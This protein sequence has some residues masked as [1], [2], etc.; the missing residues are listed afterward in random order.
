GCCASTPTSPSSPH[1]SPYDDP[2]AP[3][4]NTRVIT[5]HSSANA[6]ATAGLTTHAAPGP[7]S[8]RPNVYTSSDNPDII[9]AATSLLTSTP[10][11]T[12]SQLERERA[13]FFDTRW[14][15]RAEVWAAVKL[16]CESLRQ[17]D[18]EA[19]QAV[20]DAAGLTCPTGEVRRAGDKQKDGGVYDELGERYQVPLW[21]MA[22]PEGVVEDGHNAGET[23]REGGAGGQ[24]AEREEGYSDEDDDDIMLSKE[25]GKGREVDVGRIVKVRARLSDRGTDVVVRMGLEENV[26]M[27][28]RRVKESAELPPRSRVKF[29]YL[30]KMLDPSMSLATQGWRE[31]HVI[32]ALVFQ[33]P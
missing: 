7:A 25:K 20:L 32:N 27:L 1:D 23:P 28:R 11:V 18:L 12:R 21:V 31:G 19:A 33:P 22:D 3:I 8:S 24:E 2:N 4:P 13:A 16:I 26:V 6:S 5:N 14:S 29:A 10:R 15:G 17:Q 30:G 9:H